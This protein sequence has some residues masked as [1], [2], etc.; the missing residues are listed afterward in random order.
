MTKEANLKSEIRAAA[1]AFFTAFDH[2]EWETF[3]SLIASD[4]TVIMPWPSVPNR[5]N[6]K[7]EIEAVFSPFFEKIPQ[8]QPGPPYLNL[9]PL[10]LEIQAFGDVGL[11]T[12]H[13]DEE[14]HFGRRSLLFEKRENRWMLV[15]LHASNFYQ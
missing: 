9:A 1:E 12:F 14:D 7:S 6:G 10:E 15:H 3:S 13:L 5:L 8:Q 4:A 11:V 2:L